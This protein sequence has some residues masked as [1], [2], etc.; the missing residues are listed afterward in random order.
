MAR[1]RNAC[2]QRCLAFIRDEAPL[3]VHFYAETT[4]PL[5]LRDTHYRNQFETGS[6][7]GTLDA[8][9]RCGRALTADA[10]ASVLLRPEQQRGL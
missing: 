10:C 6:S 2:T 9:S 4:L 7:G 3:V 8:Y 5:L 1:A